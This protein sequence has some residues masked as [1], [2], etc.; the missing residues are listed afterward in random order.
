MSMNLNLNN[1]LFSQLTNTQNL[2][3][4][5][6]TIE[7]KLFPTI[8]PL[9]GLNDIKYTQTFDSFGNVSLTPDI[10]N[11]S[12]KE[13]SVIF[14]AQMGAYNQIG[15][16]ANNQ[17]NAIQL[18]DAVKKTGVNDA[19]DL[20]IA[21]MLDEVRETT[22][23]VGVDKNGNLAQVSLYDYVKEATQ[24]K[25]SREILQMSLDPNLDPKLKTALYLRA[26]VKKELQKTAKGN[27]KR[28]QERMAEDPETERARKEAEESAKRVARGANGLDEKE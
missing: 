5:K 1:G 4:E 24:G 9:S 28:M 25:T 26:Q 7:S 27:M 21:P 19:A 6:N 17:N 15:A 18:A 11:L 10:S 16:Y 8:N 22:I 3:A 20:V 2:F 12:S 23:G 14:K 13:A